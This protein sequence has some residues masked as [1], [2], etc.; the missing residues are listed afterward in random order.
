MHDEGSPSQAQTSAQVKTIGANGMTNF[1]DIRLRNASFM[2]SAAA[3][4]RLRLW[5]GRGP[6]GFFRHVTLQQNR[7]AFLPAYFAGEVENNARSVPRCDRCAVTAEAVVDA[8]GDH[9]H[10]LSDPVVDKSG[11]NQ[12]DPVNEL[13]ASP[14]NR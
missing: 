13:L 2:R 14:M 3:Y 8:R 4:R 9:I 1:G 10:V 5:V 12:H 6:Y 7:P 11:R